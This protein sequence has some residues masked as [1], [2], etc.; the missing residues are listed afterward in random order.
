M[1]LFPREINIRESKNAS[2]VCILNV[3]GLAFN[4]PMKGLGLAVDIK[5][6]IELSNDLLIPIIVDGHD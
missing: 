3:E 2:K 6:C 4:G 1:Y 5:S